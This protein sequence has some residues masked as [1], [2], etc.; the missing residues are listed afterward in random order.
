MKMEENLENILQEAYEVFA[1][2]YR[3]FSAE[4]VE[5]LF[6]IAFWSGWKAAGGTVPESDV[7]DITI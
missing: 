3:N 5:T 1:D 4:D 6:A 7:C 2:E